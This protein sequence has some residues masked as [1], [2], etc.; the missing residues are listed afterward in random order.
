MT[1]FIIYHMKKLVFYLA[2]AISFFCLFSCNKETVNKKNLEGTWGLVRVEYWEKVDGEKTDEGSID[3]NPFAPTAD[4]CLKWDIINTI[5]ND[6][7]VTW[8]SWNTRRS[9]WEVDNSSSFSFTVKGNKL[10]IEDEEEGTL[11]VTSDN[12]IFESVT[13]SEESGVVYGKEV[14]VKV[15]SSYKFVFRKMNEITE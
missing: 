11:S 5:D 8:Y 6:Y 9:A 15:E 2:L 10:Y 1:Y 12:L 13:E 4:Y 3:C 7:H 14:T